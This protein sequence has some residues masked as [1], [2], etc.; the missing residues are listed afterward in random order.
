MLIF[1]SVVWLGAL[2]PSSSRCPLWLSLTDGLR[3]KLGKYVEMA[4]WNVNAVQAVEL[5]L[6]L[7]GPLAV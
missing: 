3:P 7:A 2:L 1:V 6:S 5:L 4:R